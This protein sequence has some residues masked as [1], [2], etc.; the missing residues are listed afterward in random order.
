M[1]IAYTAQTETCTLLLDA[2]GICRSVVAA[3][4]QKVA[5]GGGRPTRIPASAEK[6]IGAQYV[7]TLD[8]TEPGGMSPLPQPGAQMLF[9]R[10]ET[11]GRITLIR[12]APVVRFEATSTDAKESG[13]HTRPTVNYGEDD[14][15]T[16]PFDAPTA[17]MRRSS[18]PPAAPVRNSG[19]V[20]AGTAS[21]ATIPPPPPTVRDPAPPPM[22]RAPERRPSYAPPPSYPPPSEYRPARASNAPPQKRPSV[23][24]VSAPFWEAATQPFKRAAR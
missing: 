11:N 15:L 14:E 3:S 17:A 22:S 18:L 9:A 12:S 8:L 23:V 20:P 6:C 24:R 10:T 1:D 5:R 7:A 4:N 19:V 2:E 13:V 21:R 16:L